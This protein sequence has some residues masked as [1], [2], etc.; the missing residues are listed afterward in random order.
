MQASIEYRGK[1]G[2]EENGK[3][4]AGGFTFSPEDRGLVEEV[5]SI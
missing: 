3:S 5:C 1:W 2:I 4:W